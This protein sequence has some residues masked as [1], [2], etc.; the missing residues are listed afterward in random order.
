M[1]AA[2]TVAPFR[3]LVLGGTGFL[4]RHL[5][6]AALARGH[7]VTL[8]NRGR[9]AP[10]LFRGVEEIRGDRA[11][12][13]PLAGRRWDAAVDTSGMHPALVRASARLLAGSVDHYTY[14]SSISV[15]AGLAEPGVHE[16][17]PLLPPPEV[18]PIGVTEES[19]GALKA[20]A[21]AEAEAALPGRVLVVRPGLIV[22]PWD[23]SDRF[24]YW[25]RRV[26][27]GGRVLAPG[28]PRRPVQFVDAR[29]L[30]EW[31]LRMAEERRA[32]TFNAVGPQ[33]RLEME[34]LLES[35]RVE[36]DSGAELA[37]ASDEFLL[38]HGVAPWKEL[39]L[40]I[41]ELLPEHRAFME[42]SNARAVAAGLTFR[43]IL[44]TVRDVR[45]WQEQ[46]PVDAFALPTLSA[47]REEQLLRM[48]T[49]PAPA[50]STPR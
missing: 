28:S 41:P 43:K 10:G 37:W 32:G 49:R 14:V 36:A 7:R 50:R 6:E 39:P 48:L 46:H 18:M 42:V 27:R 17:S 15:Y 30:A 2:V 34:W 33:R 29:D 21:E 44:E 16:G 40:W 45:A 23:P 4:G 35:I 20:M 12:P 22:G 24:G 47:A 1:P 9:S 5:V 3:L 11:D 13:S 26:A 25:V 38:E 8:F 31:V 19:Y